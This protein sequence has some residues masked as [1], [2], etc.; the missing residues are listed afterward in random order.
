MRQR[1]GWTDGKSDIEVGAPPKKENIFF[2]NRETKL[3]DATIR[4]N[5]NTNLS[6]FMRTVFF[7]CICTEI[8]SN[9]Y[10]YLK[11]FTSLICL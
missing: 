4:N 11:N 7:S 3:F 1:E 10:S 6:C 9:G 2:F 8:E 5:L